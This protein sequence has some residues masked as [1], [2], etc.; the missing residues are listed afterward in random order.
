MQIN[1]TGN[2]I[3]LTGA[4][5]DYVREKFRRL[6]RHYADALDAHVILTEESPILKKAEATLHVAGH[7]LFAHAEHKDL[8]AAIDAMVDK[9]DR[10]L[11]KTKEKQT[12]HHRNGGAL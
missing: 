11:V 1:L 12:A 2:H 3:E 7:T 9:L 10:Q 5:E 4:L 6:E 8:Y